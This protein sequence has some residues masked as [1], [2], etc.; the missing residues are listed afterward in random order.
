MGWLVTRHALPADGAAS[1]WSIRDHHASG[2]F[3][4]VCP[5][6]RFSKT[7]DS[8]DLDSSLCCKRR[9]KAVVCQFRKPVPRVRIHSAPPM[10][11]KLS[12]L[13]LDM[14]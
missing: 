4:P 3:E 2:R 11:L 1:I 5:I 8:T 10:S 7:S 12:I 14:Y 13:F 6:A 9:L